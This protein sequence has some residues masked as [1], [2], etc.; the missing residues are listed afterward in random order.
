MPSSF[1]VVRAHVPFYQEATSRGSWYPIPRLLVAEL[2]WSRHR[3]SIVTAS[4]RLVQLA[5]YCSETTT[6]TS[7]FERQKHGI[8]VFSR[9][10]SAAKLCRACVCI[11]NIDHSS[12]RNH[13]LGFGMILMPRS[14]GER[15]ALARRPT[16]YRV[17][18]SVFRGS[19]PLASPRLDDYCRRTAN[20]SQLI[21][22]S[23]SEGQA[24][25]QMRIWQLRCVY[26]QLIK[27]AVVQAAHVQCIDSLTIATSI[28]SDRMK[29]YY[30]LAH[31][32]PF[33]M[34]RMNHPNYV[35]HS[36]GYVD[37]LR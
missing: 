18:P 37:A 32:I 17:V 15:P 6:V 8:A 5:K 12:G 27:A 9:G 36:V 14:S 3:A 30:C 10:T 20:Q 1:R 7:T 2:V 34:N 31:P 33:A 11:S 23:N 28:G 22:H 25:L 29:V 35:R 4:W 19:K 26:T 16:L 13:H 21:C 24:G